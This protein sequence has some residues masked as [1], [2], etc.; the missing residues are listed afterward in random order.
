MTHTPTAVFKLSKPAKARLA[1][2]LDPHHRGA[3]K[4]SLIQAEMESAM[5]PKSDKSDR[6]QRQDQPKQ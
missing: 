2:I 4:R 5:K 3:I 1:R 6:G